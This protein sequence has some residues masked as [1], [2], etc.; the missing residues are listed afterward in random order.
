MR[1]GEILQ[2]TL[3]G[4]LKNWRTAGRLGK[5]MLSLFNVLKLE[6]LGGYIHKRKALFLGNTH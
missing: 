4:Q 3:L 6:T 5:R 1:V 2:R